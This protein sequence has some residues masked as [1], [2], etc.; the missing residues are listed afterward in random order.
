MKYS[1]PK[2]ITTSRLSDTLSPFAAITICVTNV[3][4]ASKKNDA[5]FI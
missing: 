4:T 3:F 1:T 5:I 2:V